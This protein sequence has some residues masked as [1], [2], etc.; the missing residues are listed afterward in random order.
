MKVKERPTKFYDELTCFIREKGKGGIVYCVFPDN[1]S[2]IQAELVKRN[3][4]CVKYHG[5]LSLAVR[6]ASFTKW[7]SGEV[8]VNVAN[9]AFGMGINKSDVRCVVHAKLPTS[10]DDYFQQVGRVGRDGEPATCRLY[11]SRTDRT[12]LIK[13]FKQQDH[14]DEQYKALN[15]LRKYIEV[16]FS[17]DIRTLCPTMAK[18]E[19]DILVLQNVTTARIGVDLSRLMEALML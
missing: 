11:Y 5:Q 2:N 8:D 13:M 16:Q 15:D 9:S 7:S 6:E 12:A 3:I 10:I 17:V 14:F 4:I 1:V 19:M 18:R